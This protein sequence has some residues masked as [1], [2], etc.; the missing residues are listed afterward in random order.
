MD[1]DKIQCD[2]WLLPKA[3][4]PSDGMSLAL[5]YTYSIFV[6]CPLSFKQSSIVCALLGLI[7]LIL[8]S[9]MIST[10]SLLV[11]SYAQSL[12]LVH[13]G[14][15]P[16]KREYLERVLE[17]EHASFI[18]L[19]FGTNGGMGTECQKFVSELATKLAEKQNEEY[20]IGTNALLLVAVN[21]LGTISYL[22]CDKRQRKAFLET[23]Q[24][25]EV[26]LT[27]E[28]QSRE[29]ERLLLSVLP[30]HV[31]AEI[32]DD[33]GSVVTGQFKKI[34]ISRHE[35]V[36]ILFADIVGFTA[37]SSTCSAVEL[38]K[39]L[40]ELFARF[41]KLA[42]KFHQLRIKILGDCY[43]CIS[44]AP[45]QREDH[46][47]LSVHMGL[48]MVDA[49]NQDAKAKVKAAWLKFRE[50]S[51][52]MC[53]RKMPKRLKVKVYKTVIRQ[54]LLY[55]SELW[56][57]RKWERDMIERTEMRMLKW[58]FGIKRLDRVK[59]VSIRERE[60]VC[61]VTVR[62]EDLGLGK[63]LSSLFFAGREFK[64]KIPK[65]R[66]FG[67]QLIFLIRY[68]QEKTK[69]TVDMRVGIH[70]GS[71]LAGVMGQRQWQFDVYSRDVELANKMESGGLPGRVHISEKTLSFM[72]GEFEVCP[73]DG[74]TRE[75]AIRLAGIKTYLI[76]KVL[77]PYPQG[78]LDEVEEKNDGSHNNHL[79]HEGVKDCILSASSE[80]LNAAKKVTW[81][82]IMDETST[83]TRT[84][85]EDS[86]AEEYRNRLYQEL[87]SR[88]HE[89]KLY[90]RANSLTLSFEDERLEQEYSS[91]KEE[92]WS[93]SV[94][95]APITFM[96]SSLAY[97]C[98]LPVTLNYFIP[99]RI[100]N[101]YNCFKFTAPCKPFPFLDT[102]SILREKTAGEAIGLQVN[103]TKTEYI[104]Y[105]YDESDIVALNGEY[106][107]C[108]KNFNHLGSWLNNSAKDIN[109]RIGMGCSKQNGH[110]LEISTYQKALN[111][112]LQSI[113]RERYMVLKDGH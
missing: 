109:T 73:G 45:V 79:P 41:D 66:H 76:V 2:I 4:L 42:E 110:C 71:V 53:D 5:M 89:R 49:I 96:F 70:T 106:L 112:I 100:V 51:S 60:R 43:Y 20:S 88:G 92:G 30:E 86:N 44:G 37:I 65:A 10:D 93:I 34:Y 57:V 14:H 64:H 11:Q 32:R 55:R 15:V 8:P 104:M 6:L 61:S 38:V 26:K 68:V 84:D 18:P 9:I 101:V 75:E 82:V 113:S 98:I 52:I 103:V 35:N 69:S 3:G 40:N 24:S 29:Q 31:A 21:M 58:M 90:R 27:I 62:K 39:I 99:H 48:S 72:N 56:A 33:L 85:Y 16:A 19:V 94:V 78:T 46:A 17:I 81:A 63:L 108:V 23:R 54:V 13:P 25:L 59:N 95:S 102:L 7:H 77:K 50:M 67:F 111:P 74:E 83:G 80:G 91:S 107:K 36:S 47:V 105:N 22:H 97:K 1:Q 12:D 28:E 87:L